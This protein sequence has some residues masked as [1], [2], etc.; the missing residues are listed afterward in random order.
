[1]NITTTPEGNVLKDGEVV[2]SIFEGQFAPI[3]GLHPKTIKAVES[4]L[5]E[6][7][8][9]TEEKPEKK[10]SKGDAEPARCVFQGVNTP[11]YKAW[12]LKNLPEEDLA[13]MYGNDR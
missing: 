4:R 7:V 11:A 2:G 5:L 6:Q 12:A 8:S 9:E 10:T 13:K 1:M 3:E